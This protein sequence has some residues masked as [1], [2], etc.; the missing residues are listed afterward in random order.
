[1]LWHRLWSLVLPLLV[2]LVWASLFWQSNWTY[3]VLFLAAFLS[4]GGAW[5]LLA[6]KIPSLKEKFFYAGFSL[7]TVES[8]LFAF[9]L[10]ENI[11]LKIILVLATIALFLLYLNELFIQYWQKVLPQT[12]RLNLFFRFTQILIVFWLAGGLFGL[13]DFLG[14]DF[15]YLGIV[16]FALIS[17]VSCY[18][19]LEQPT[20]LK[21]WQLIAIISLLAVEMFWGLGLLPL[22]YYLKAA[23][24]AIFYALTNEI[25]IWHF[26]RSISGKLIR[27]YL[28]LVII[29][30]LL[31]L[32]TA[33]WF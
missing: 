12:E 23:F 13:R 11:F 31:L 32:G 25:L 14:A 33:Q 5:L 26:S 28:I 19:G 24:L 8:S 27:N 2:G 3:G 16:F 4:F 6:K 30:I 17:L 7:L 22:V 21:R 29:L 20:S 18:S 9:L 15:I 10:L 1:M